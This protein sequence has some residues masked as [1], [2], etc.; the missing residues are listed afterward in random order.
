MKSNVFRLSDYRRQV[1]FLNLDTI[2]MISLGIALIYA[3]YKF[4]FTFVIR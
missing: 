4:F 3:V 2:L 1:G